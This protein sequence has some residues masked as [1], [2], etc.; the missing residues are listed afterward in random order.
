ME[1]SPLP[2]T[3][4]IAHAGDGA[5]LHAPSAERNAAI[6]T[7]ALVGI[8]PATGRALEIASGTGQHIV[9]FARA[10]PGLDWQPTEVDPTRRASI[11]AWA[12]EAGLPNLGAAIPLNATQAGW[13][14]EASESALIVLINLLHLI[15]T[16]EAQTLVQEVAHALAPAGRFALYGPFLREGQT[17]S[18][19]DARF[20]ASLIAQDPAIGYKD[21]EEVQEWL[22]DAGLTLIETRAMPANNVL[23]IAERPA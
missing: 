15:S 17:T 16:P 22:R 11:D 12:A 20:H 18:D 23:L 14:A 19:G 10:M 1:Q 2:P 6:I 8:A 5:K 9:G 4:S 21:L 7:E 13:A 3:A